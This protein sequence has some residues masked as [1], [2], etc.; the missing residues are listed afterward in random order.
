M[1]YV[2]PESVNPF[3]VIACKEEVMPLDFENDG[4]SD[5]ESLFVYTEHLIFLNVFIND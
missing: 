5:L 3:G 4:L 1:K 2:P